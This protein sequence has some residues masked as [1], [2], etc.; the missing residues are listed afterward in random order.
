MSTGTIYPYPVIDQPFYNNS[1][2]T[3]L[4]GSIVQSDTVVELKMSI[5]PY[6]TSRGPLEAEGTAPVIP[7]KVA[8]VGHATNGAAALGCA[9]AEIQDGQWGTIRVYGPCLVPCSE[10]ANDLHLTSYSVDSA[11]AGRLNEVTAGATVYTVAFQV[12]ASGVTSAGDK[13]KVFMLGG[14]EQLATVGC[15]F[16]TFV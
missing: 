11:T 14:R 7:V 15:E 10:T 3:I 8:A 4:A 2:A 9:L 13:R 5:N 12:G 16:G 6:A 1:G